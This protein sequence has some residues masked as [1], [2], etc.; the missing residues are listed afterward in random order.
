MSL[1]VR[2][3]IKT[4]AFW[5]VLVGV[6]GLFLRVW[7]FWRSPALWDDELSLSINVV[8]MGY[9]D[10]LQPLQFAQ[11]APVGFLWLQRLS[12]DIF[13]PG[14]R[15]LRLP[16]L[17][18]GLAT[19]PL[20]WLVARRVAGEWAG[21]LALAL[22]SLSP[23][24]VR[25]TN[26]AK[27]YGVEAFVSAVL[28]A[29][30]L[31]Y[32]R[33]DL[34]FSSFAGLAALGCGA[35]ALSNASIFGLAA[36]A[37]LLAMDGGHLREG[38]DR[39]WLGWTCTIWAGS[40][41][42]SYAL[43]HSAD[44]QYGGYFTRFFAPVRIT[45]QPDVLAAS[46]SVLHGFLDPLFALDQ[47]MPAPLLVLA[48]ALLVIGIGEIWIAG[49]RRIALLAPLAFVLL[50]GLAGKWYMVAR[51]MMFTAPLVA[52]LLAAGSVRVA[53][54]F[55]RLRHQELAVAGISILL[56]VF[57]VK[58]D[59]YTSSHPLSFARQGVAFAR[60]QMRPGDVVYLYSKAVPAWM[61]YST[62]WRRPDRD[63]LE[64][65]A[66]ASLLTGPNG[67]NIPSRGHKVVL[68]GW[69]L[70]RPYRDAWELVGEPEGILRTAS[71]P[72]SNPP[73]SGW[74]ENEY[75]RVMRDS[76][77]RIVVI[78]LWITPRSYSQ[79][80]QSFQGS[81]FRT[82]AEYANEGVSVVVLEAP[83]PAR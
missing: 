57:P 47:R 45:E 67:G 55:S 24:C 59:R 82:V 66:A 56:L 35:I 12:V 40:F 21:A 74:V 69:D 41:G 20:L 7:A 73:D 15:S 17:I 62:D 33:R 8:R 32:P 54:L 78:G 29:A 31:F 43:F 6:A 80:L 36:L 46:L 26:E 65:L 52:V 48:A 42:L 53:S 2:R 19:L 61:F 39:W 75:E 77:G 37:W 10:L 72:A 60:R 5:A 51:L 44:V 14:E 83:P 22:A 18:T 81:G 9:L 70:R 76:K 13:G 58:A 63:R 79:F 64:W 49:E 50:A 23:Y 25:Y 28:L 38:R 71:G 16:A 34:K 3:F 27:Q 30:A 1:E 4:P 68:E 11:S